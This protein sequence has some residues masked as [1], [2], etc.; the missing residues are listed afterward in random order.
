MILLAIAFAAWNL[1][2]LAAGGFILALALPEILKGTSDDWGLAFMTIAA[3]LGAIAN[4]ALFLPAELLF[5]LTARN[6]DWRLR[7]P[8]PATL[9]LA[10]LLGAAPSA[11]TDLRCYAHYGEFPAGAGIGWALALGIGVVTFGAATLA[12]LL[13][14]RQRASQDSPPAGQ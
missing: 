5:A 9:A 7:A 8:I 6:I 11:V 13:V 4:F 10:I 3:G 1:L 14:W 2:S 12:Y